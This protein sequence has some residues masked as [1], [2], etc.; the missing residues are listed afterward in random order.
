[1]RV[2]IIVAWAALA[3][4]VYAGDVSSVA[5][6]PNEI[7]MY[8]GDVKVLEGA[9]ISDVAI[10]NSEVIK[11]GALQGRGIMLTARGPGETTLHLWQNGVK[12]TYAVYV[13]AENLERIHREVSALLGN[14]AGVSI[15]SAGN[16][17]VVD[18]RDV[19]AYD[20]R[21]IARLLA[22]YPTVIN[23]LDD[24]TPDSGQMIYMDVR[25]IELSR[26]GIS[27]LG[28]DWS[29]DMAGPVM[30]TAG[31]FHRSGGFQKG[32]LPD[33]T[34][35]PASSRISPF[36]TYFGVVTRL[37]SRINLLEQ[38]GEALM[39]AHPILSCRNQ[40]KASFLSGGQVPFA[41]AS[42]TG[43]PSVEFKD[44]GIKL[45]I[46]PALGEDSAI[47]AKI[48]AEVSDL[49]KSTTVNG[50]PGLLTRKTETEFTMK[51]GETIVLSG[52]VNQM[53]GKEENAVPGLGR[54]PLLGRLFKSKS[55]NSRRNELVIFVTPM[56]KEA[57]SASLETIS[58]A[59]QDVVQAETAGV[60]L[61]K[62]LSPKVQ[63]MPEGAPP[64]PDSGP[65]V[66][67]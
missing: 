25:I 8:A 46:E 19:A 36:Q 6:E 67:P 9:G 40:G 16:S 37:D 63:N 35:V 64:A 39:V 45:D 28:V 58:R 14:I 4:C 66:A 24:K 26:S 1:M 48:A 22:A 29:D 53:T 43:T 56:I 38:S 21:K 30:A 23:L 7:R 32:I 12:Q 3:S 49:D 52:L 20:R 47:L 57:V 51:L 42:A 2:V 15:R 33:L 59:S 13:Q 5:S 10:G 41:T 17:L 34:N 54:L 50:V 11:A 60:R 31:D 65:Q 55:R 61:V 62:P 18:G 27:S 44:Y